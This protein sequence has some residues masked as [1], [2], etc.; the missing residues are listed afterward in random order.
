MPISFETIAALG[1]GLGL[2]AACG[3][4]VFVPLL[5]L[6]V[7]ARMDLV[8]LVP[9]W[10]WMAS[11]PAIIAFGSATALEVVGYYIPWFDHLLDIVATPAAVT[12]G[13][14]VSSAVIA[15]LPPL[16]RWTAILVGG[17]GLAAFVQS[18]TVGLRA[19]SGATTGGLANPV[20]AT[21][22]LAGATVTSVLAV[23]LPLLVL[24]VVVAAALV[25]R[26]LARRRTAR[27]RAASGR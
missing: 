12:A 10:E 15:D 27:G 14:L 20:V 24:F 4:R 18:S 16:V 7:A 26:R 19:A 25:A 9:G 2:A 1:L 8:P 3:F 11:L 21:V 5:V 6:G 22:E 17:G 23:L 13:L